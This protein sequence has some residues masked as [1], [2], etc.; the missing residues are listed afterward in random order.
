MAT[1]R[2]VLLLGALLLGQ[3]CGSESP[4]PT[5]ETPSPGP[6]SQDMVRQQVLQLDR[7]VEP[8]HLLRQYDVEKLTKLGL[9][10]PISQIVD[11]LQAHPE[12]IPF[13]GVLGGTMGFYHPDR[14]HVLN[15]N[16]VYAE[17]DDGHVCGHGVFAY[18]ILAD[19]SFAWTLVTAALQ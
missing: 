18:A 3:G 14:I 19:T 16:W 12:I 11:S 2:V 13:D 9:S 5:E 6:A 15:P 8:G 1:T 10:D 7:L 4:P 17:F